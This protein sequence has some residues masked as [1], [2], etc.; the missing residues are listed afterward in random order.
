MMPNRI[1]LALAAT[2]VAL[3]TLSSASGAVADDYYGA[4]VE[5]WLW[6]P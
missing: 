3:A 4:Y 2:L 1:R 6:G 5:G